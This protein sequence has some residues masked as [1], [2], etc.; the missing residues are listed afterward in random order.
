MFDQPHEDELD[1]ADVKGQESVKRTL[2]IA[3]TGGHNVIMMYVVIHHPSLTVF[4]FKARRAIRPERQGD[5]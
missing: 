2:E 3:A 1:F 5:R 4:F